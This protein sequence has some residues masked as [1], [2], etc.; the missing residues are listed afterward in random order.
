MSTL[1]YVGGLLERR[2]RQKNYPFVQIK[3]IKLTGT[4]DKKNSGQNNGI[5]A[6]KQ[7]EI[8]FVQTNFQLKLLLRKK[9]LLS[10]MSQSQI[11]KKHH[12]RGIWEKPL[13]L[14]LMMLTE[15]GI[16]DCR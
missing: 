6:I 12:Q 4:E 10:C 14:S 13:S 9:I 16:H 15:H 1:L 7:I 5:K 8:N 11:P 2:R 3:L